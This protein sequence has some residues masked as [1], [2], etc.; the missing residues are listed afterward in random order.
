MQ[1]DTWN[2]DHMNISGDVPGGVKFVPGPL[3]RASLAP[4]DATYSGLLECPMTTRIT[5]QIDGTYTSQTQ[6]NCQETIQTFQECYHAAATTIAS[7]GQTFVNSTGS[8]ANQPAGCSATLNMD[9]HTVNVFFNKLSTS[10]IECAA[11]AETIVGFT[12]SLVQT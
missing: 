1:I 2:R 8:D 10:K 3:P 4:Q 11:G 7:G 12:D 6:G 5:K 9:T